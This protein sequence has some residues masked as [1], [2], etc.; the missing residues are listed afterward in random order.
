MIYNKGTKFKHG[1]LPAPSSYLDI[2]IVNE[3][4]GK[5][6]LSTIDN[7][8]K[9]P[10][11]GILNRH[12]FE[13]YEIDK[14][15]KV[16]SLTLKLQTIDLKHYFEVN[17]NFKYKII[18]TYTFWENYAKKTSLFFRFEELLKNK[19]REYV[20]K[21]FEYSD[22]KL[23]E[24]KIIEFENN[25]RET[26]IENLKSHGIE[27]FEIDLN[28]EIPPEIKSMLERYKK[29]QIFNK[30]FKLPTKNYDF[31][32]LPDINYILTDFSILTQSDKFIA[33]KF[34]D[35]IKTLLSPISKNESGDEYKKFEE[36]INSSQ[37]NFKKQM[38]IN[39]FKL[40]KINFHIEPNDK[41]ANLPKDG[42]YNYEF[43]LDSK[44]DVIGKFKI[45]VDFNYRID[46]IPLFLDI[47]PSSIKKI[48]EC[49]LKSFYS[50]LTSEYY[51]CDIKNLKNKVDISEKLEL[52]NKY[53]ESIGISLIGILSYVDVQDNSDITHIMKKNFAKNLYVTSKTDEYRFKISISANYNY[54]RPDNLKGLDDENIEKMLHTILKQIIQSVSYNYET[55]QH[56]ELERY[57]NKFMYNDEIKEHLRKDGFTINKYHILILDAAIEGPGKQIPMC[58]S[59]YIGNIE[60]TITGDIMES[61]FVRIEY[62]FEIKD[63]FYK[64]VE[65][66]RKI[67]N[68]F[69]QSGVNKIEA[70][71]KNDEEWYQTLDK[72]ILEFKN[73]NIKD[74]KIELIVYSISIINESQ[75]HITNQIADNNS[76]TIM[77]KGVS[78]VKN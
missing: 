54:I 55:N 67:I 45:T 7:V 77:N 49:K 34:L 11:I 9:S 68:G 65:D 35:I 28:I 17:L 69:L 18:N 42:T 41:I 10:K 32:V 62:T 12:A 46:N 57:L 63:V 66:Y 24:R 4:T 13:V 6:F 64:T 2:I 14:R 59:I 39:G 27:V 37:E 73:N 60:M 58:N 5:S 36:H 29:I 50:S 23:L 44:D 56:I 31:K 26:E 74:K 15:E 38:A 72:I 75:N 3:V 70:N 25:F 1:N 40:L 71:I 22:L 8:Y 30:E 33:E 52:N 43:K 78:N 20:K 19:I 53:F 51:I 76:K 48:V 61:K 47:G 21:F 16:I